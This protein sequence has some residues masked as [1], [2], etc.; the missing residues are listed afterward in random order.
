MQGYLFVS[1]LLYDEF[2]EQRVIIFGV[3][4]MQGH[5]VCSMVGVL[6]SVW[7]ISVSRTPSLFSTGTVIL[8]SLTETGKFLS[9]RRCVRQPSR[10]KYPSLDNRRDTP[11]KLEQIRQMLQARKLGGQVM[12]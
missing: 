7:K 3:P 1:A 5:Q 2:T 10:L 4:V 8:L 6:Q 11:D 12:G 9:H